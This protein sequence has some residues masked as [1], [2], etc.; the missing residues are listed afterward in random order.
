LL[1]QY[2]QQRISI[3]YIHYDMTINSLLYGLQALQQNN[4]IKKI[5]ILLSGRQGV[6]INLF[7]FIQGLAKSI[8][9]HVVPMPQLDEEFQQPKTISDLGQHVA[10][11]ISRQN[12]ML[13]M[14]FIY[15]DFHLEQELLLKQVAYY[16]KMVFL[17]AQS[18]SVIWGQHPI[19]KNHSYLN[20][21]FY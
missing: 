9:T 5:N 20:P 17:S 4:E 14:K 10:D 13:M 18:L 2:Y 15:W 8:V 3:K 11:F 6:F 16:K 21:I 12:R 1:E 19:F 7:E